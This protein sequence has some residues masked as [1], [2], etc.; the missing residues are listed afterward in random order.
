MNHKRKMGDH[1]KYLAFQSFWNITLKYF[2]DVVKARKYKQLK[3]SWIYPLT[4]LI[5][6]IMLLK[7]GY[8]HK[9]IPFKWHSTINY[10]DFVMLFK[11]KTR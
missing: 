10:K 6:E 11:C 2:C 9:D 5:I 8:L 4:L 7:F 3:V 1:W